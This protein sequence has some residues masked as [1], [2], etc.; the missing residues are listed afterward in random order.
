[1]TITGPADKIKDAVAAAKAAIVIVN[2][3]KEDDDEP[4]A[5]KERQPPAQAR[6]QMKDNSSGA[7]NAWHYYDYQ[8]YY[9]TRASDSRAWFQV[10]CPVSYAWPPVVRPGLQLQAPP[11]FKYPTEPTNKPISPFD[12]TDDHG[13]PVVKEEFEE[14]NEEEIEEEPRP[15]K[16]S[17][18][19]WKSAKK[20]IDDSDL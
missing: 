13:P 17:R 1:M 7:W 12:Y 18:R 6:K 4:P 16:H 9:K 2:E 10:C 19:I 14:E 8:G 15:K 11:T 5:W 3:E 20:V